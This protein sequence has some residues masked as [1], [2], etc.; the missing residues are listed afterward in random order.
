MTSSFSLS[1]YMTY[2]GIGISITRY[3]SISSQLI[4]AT[5][6]CL[7]PKPNTLYCVCPPGYSN[8]GQT[9]LLLIFHTGVTRVDNQFSSRHLEQPHMHT[10]GNP[11]L[12]QSRKRPPAKGQGRD[13]V[14]IFCSPEPSLGERERVFFHVA[15]ASY[16]FCLDQIKCWINLASLKFLALWTTTGGTCPWDG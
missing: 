5:T 13:F 9:L 11:A 2:R 16:N 7:E 4:R 3:T 8:K 10:G 1:I 6:G 14:S 12:M 15:L